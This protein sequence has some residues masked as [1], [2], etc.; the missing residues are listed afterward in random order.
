MPLHCPNKKSVLFKDLMKL[1]DNNEDLVYHYYDVVADLQERGLISKK[2]FRELDPNRVFYYIPKHVTEESIARS[3]R[4]ES[5][6]AKDKLKYNALDR[7]LTEKDI[8][9]MRIIETKESYL[10]ELLGKD[11]QIT[12]KLRNPDTKLSIDEA[13]Q[14]V[15]NSNLP[16]NIKTLLSTLAYQSGIDADI[17]MSDN[18]IVNGVEVDGYHK[19]NPRGKEIVVVRRG[20][21]AAFILAHELIH[22]AT[23]KFLH[24][25]ASSLNR[26]QLAAR[27]ELESLYE[28]AKSKLEGKVLYGLKNLDEFVAEAFTNEEFQKELDNIQ[29]REKSLLARIWDNLVML[30]TGNPNSVL[31]RTLGAT[32][33]LVASGEVKYAETTIISLKERDILSKIQEESHAI[34]ES[35]DQTRYEKVGTSVKYRRISD[36][37]DGGLSKFLAR[38]VSE[39]TPAERKAINYWDKSGYNP[40][41][42]ILT[43]EFPNEK[44]TKKMY[45]DKFDN[46]LKRGLIK[47]KIIH[48][49]MQYYLSQDSTERIKLNMEIQELALEAGIIDPFATYGWVIGEK[50]QTIEKILHMSG[51]NAGVATP[52]NIRD[53]VVSEIKVSNDTLGLAGRIDTLVEHPDG[54]LSIIDW[55]TG[56]TFNKHDFT[57]ILKY[58][59]QE[60]EIFDNPRERAKLQIMLYALTIKASHPDAKFRH[61]RVHWIPNEYEATRDDNKKDVEVRSYLKMVELYYK[62]EEPEAYKKLLKE[63]PKIFDPAEYTSVSSSVATEMITK[64]MSAEDLLTHSMAELRIVG[65]KI[66]EQELL[67]N[68]ISPSLLEKQARLAATIADIKK[69]PGAGNLLDAEDISMVTQWI[70]AYE[71]VSN[72]M[73]MTVKLLQNERKALAIQKLD[74]INKQFSVLLNAVKKDYLRKSGKENIDSLTRGRLNFINYQDMFAFAFKT[75]TRDEFTEEKLVTEDDAEW[76]KLTNDQKKLLTFM[77]DH[78]EEQFKTTMNKVALDDPQTGKKKTFLDLY[79][80]INPSF[81]YSRG[82]FPKVPMSDSEIR[83]RNGFISKNNLRYTIDK[84]MTSFIED[85]YEAPDMEFGM[86]VKYLGNARITASGAYTRNLE[87]MF[88]KFMGTMVEKEYMDDVYAFAK[89]VQT[90]LSLRTVDGKPK[91]G[92]TVK[93]LEGKIM[94]DLLKKDFTPKW[95]RHG[96]NLG[97]GRKVNVESV[98][99]AIKKLTSYTIMWLKPVSG[100]ANGLFGFLHAGNK[101]LQGLVAQKF[102]GI[103]G[104]QVDYTSEDWAWAWKEWSKMQIDF[105]V[106]NGK[107]NKTYMLLRKLRF[108]PD[109]LGY[110]QR[111]ADRVIERNPLLDV[112]HFYMTHSVW[113]D[114]NATIMMLAQLRHMKIEK[115]GKKISLFDAYD[116]KDIID[117]ETGVKYKDVVWTAGRRGWIKKSYTGVASREDYQELT[118]LSPE[119]IAK[120]KRVYVLQQG[121]YREDEKTVLEGYV[122]GQMFLQFKKYMPAVLMGS[123]KS[124]GFDASLGYYEKVGQREDG[125]DLYEWKL[126]ET[127]GRWRTFI[128]HVTHVLS[129]QALA[130]SYDWSSLT[131]DQKQNIVNGYTTIALSL[132]GMFAYMQMFDDDDERDEMR[133]ITKRVLEN[134]SQQFNPE[135]LIKGI[136]SSPATIVRT[137]KLLKATTDMIYASA[138]YAIGNEKEAFTKRGNL[139]GLTEFQKSIPIIASWHSFKKFF[140]QNNTTEGT[141]LHEYMLQYQDNYVR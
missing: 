94:V 16:K 8:D 22:S 136:A 21:N 128:G 130:K 118:E 133:L 107:N 96:V 121:G 58:G 108:L 75:V 68:M 85:T 79:K 87:D 131:N 103:N 77:H 84:T 36:G 51:I 76:S 1:N 124:K 90:H 50:G 56:S 2:Q 67:G 63:S 114:A 116:V 42:E 54:Y 82:Y 71:D 11:T 66:R 78:M 125:E 59:N 72:P 4:G 12:S 23:I 126:R 115:N 24:A 110:T 122:L 41:E 5:P 91:F 134:F 109:D 83:Q 48:A 127:E 34:Q 35:H 123:L 129:G 33:T 49:M 13:L 139:H 46:R 117:S 132:M 14:I 15:D 141:W 38:S 20:L 17:I 95:T 105:M 27:S 113:E 100:T 138:Y 31:A 135:D 88:T 10:V 9:W 80:R 120:M 45:I 28:L 40:N 61:L 19:T 119:E 55:K 39:Y 47:G 106:G 44:L 43:P 60:I 53:K 98:M 137:G 6:W 81:S 32:M 29:V 73:V 89:G 69:Y 101:G 104:S 3:F 74:K 30:F 37:K 111:K 93:F 70:G 18:P 64:N 25:P 97:H 52:D 7:I 57:N 65:N 99:K 62:N 140:K 102:V 92:N 112:G 86:P 26:E